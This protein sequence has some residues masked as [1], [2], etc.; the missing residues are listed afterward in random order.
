[1]V[2]GLGTQSLAS[3]LT[4]KMYLVFSTEQ[5]MSSMA[6]P[7]GEH[8]SSIS[9]MKTTVFLMGTRDVSVE[10]VDGAEKLQRVN[11]HVVQIQSLS[12]TQNSRFRCLDYHVPFLPLK[13][14][15]TFLAKIDATTY[16]R[17]TNSN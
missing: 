2:S 5:F 8:A 12:A 16:R 9:A 15:F 3:L 14:F 6:E 4:V 10:N 17:G 7:R 11:T 13:P 1:M